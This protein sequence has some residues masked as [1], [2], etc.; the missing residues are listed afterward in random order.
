MDTFSASIFV[1]IFGR[2]LDAFLTHFGHPLD[3]KCRQQTV[4]NQSEKCHRKKVV[5]GRSGPFRGWPSW[6]PEGAIIKEVWILRRSNYSRIRIFGDLVIRIFG[7]VFGDLD[8]RRRVLHA[9]LVGR[10]MTGS[11]LS[12]YQ[13]YGAARNV[14]SGKK[15]KNTGGGFGR[16]NGK[17]LRSDWAI[18]GFL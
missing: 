8:I 2:I 11:A 3:T 14:S 17:T 10:R 5:P 9:D 6:G 18:G 4:K 15:L 1:L 12:E 7:I 13:R 16:G